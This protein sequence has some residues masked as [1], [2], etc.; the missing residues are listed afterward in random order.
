MK[1][2]YI[3]NSV[4]PSRSANSLQVM[5]MCE[6]F[7]QR[8]YEVTLLAPSRPSEYEKVGNTFD[9]YGINEC[10][11]I[12]K[13]RYPRLRGRRQIYALLIAKELNT[14]KPDLAYGRFIFGCY[15]SAKLGYKT[16]FESHIAMEQRSRLE[17]WYIRRLAN[18][19]N[20]ERLVVISHAQKA[21]YLREGI[22]PENKIQVA[23]SVADELN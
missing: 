6:A 17:R 23:N 1:I 18:C 2:A 10:F 13:L 4:I 8:G 16:V 22:L 11:K 20:F 21:M 5:K 7:V 12:K 14:I 15:F 3:S 19:A 9:F